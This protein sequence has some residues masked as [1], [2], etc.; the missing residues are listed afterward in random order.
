MQMTYIHFS[1]NDFFL[2][3]PNTLSTSAPTFL[4][5]S[6]SHYFFH[7][8]M[9]A[10]AFISYAFK[11]SMQNLIKSASSCYS[12]VLLC[13]LSPSRIISSQKAES[14]IQISFVFLEMITRILWAQQATKQG[15]GHF[16]LSDILISLNK[17][18]NF[19]LYQY[20]DR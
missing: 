15:L 10:L 8:A 17:L 2:S 4:S 11:S 12:T 7:L 6:N 1:L 20:F 13:V 9:F 3:S 18:T 14:M 19:S 5:K 16:S